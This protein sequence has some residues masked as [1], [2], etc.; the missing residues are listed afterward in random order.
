MPDL[1]RQ[2]PYGD[3]R[4]LRRAVPALFW[5]H[6]N[7]YGRFGLDMNS[8]LDLDLPIRVA[9]PGPHTPLGEAATAPT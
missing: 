6:V 2:S 4:D 3:L 7:P 8:R 5:T 1:P 9:A